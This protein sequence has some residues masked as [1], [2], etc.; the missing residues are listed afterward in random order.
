VPESRIAIVGG[1]QA[2]GRVALS[3][4]ER[5]YG[6]GITIIGDEPH[7]P[8]E[9]PPLSKGIITGADA[10]DSLYL[11]PEDIWNARDIEVRSGVA[12][13]AIRLPERLLEL[14][15]G[16]TLRFDDL[17]IAT[18]ARARR[19][20]LGEGGPDISYLRT[21]ADALSLREKLRPG[22]R[23]VIVGA[24][25]IGLELASSA[26]AMNVE[27]DVVETAPCVMARQVGPAVSR[28]LQRRHEEAG[29]RFHLGQSV[30]GAR[31]VEAGVVLSTSKGTSLEGDVVVVAIGVVPN[32]DLARRAG[33]ACQD[34]VIVD[35]A[36]RSSAPHVWAVGDVAR[37]PV[38][39][40]PTTV[41]QETW[42]HAD[43]HARAVAAALLGEST[44][45]SEVPG[46][47]SDQF[48]SRLQGEGVCSGDEVFIDQAGG[49]PVWV[50]HADGRV[51][52]C[53]AL[54][55][56]KLATIARKAIGRGATVDPAV[57]L[58]PGADLKRLLR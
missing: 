53:I 2:G 9:R 12:A 25:V 35:G 7:P 23:L 42:R 4:R 47:W 30:V 31:W 48:G 22:R 54:D 45:Y 28:V 58:A 6:G 3:L 36:G 44:K 37:H 34:G 11:E 16:G 19:L 14:G 33:I 18:G 13:T 43:R 39:W 10:L 5:G 56:P 49:G 20:P 26:R 32:D 29:T 52:G 17:V 57:L 51:T 55:N 21:Q 50:Y 38:S 41:R 46:F 8:Y 15:D 40:S 27:V 1:G 24:G